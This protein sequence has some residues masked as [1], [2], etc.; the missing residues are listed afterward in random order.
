MIL[1]CYVKYNSVLELLDKKKKSM[2]FNMS[3]R[4]LN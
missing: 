4:S 3:E 2:V 1:T